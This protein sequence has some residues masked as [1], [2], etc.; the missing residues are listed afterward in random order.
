MLTLNNCLQS[1]QQECI[2]G[3]LKNNDDH[4][5]DN[6]NNNNGKT[7]IVNVINVNYI[8]YAEIEY[9]LQTIVHYTGNK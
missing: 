8:T 7:D 9:Q 4:D 6:N 3:N 5:D 1:V 2:N